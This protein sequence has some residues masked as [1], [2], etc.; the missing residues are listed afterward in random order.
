MRSNRDNRKK[1]EM[2]PSDLNLTAGCK[3]YINKCHCENVENI[4]FSLIY[5]GYSNIHQHCKQP[6]AI[7]FCSLSQR[8]LD[9][10]AT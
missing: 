9:Q 6:L 5:V 10:C 1:F 2:I 8:I 3:A 7:C 4:L